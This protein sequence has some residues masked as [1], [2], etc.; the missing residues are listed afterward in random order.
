MDYRRHSRAERRKEPTKRIPFDR[1]KKIRNQLEVRTEK[2]DHKIVIFAV[3]EMVA[4]NCQAIR[5]T[6]EE[7]M[8]P[9]DIKH[10]ILDIKDVPFMDSV[11]VGMLVDL[12]QQLSTL[13]IDFAISR[14]SPQVRWLIEIL[15][16]DRILRVV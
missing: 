13:K 12:K 15:R 5:D 4:E 9:Q 3:H 10:V 11:A 1:R 16:L 6:L 8:N 14:P 7:S 2:N